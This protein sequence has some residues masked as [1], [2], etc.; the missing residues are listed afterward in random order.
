MC[1]A[2]GATSLGQGVPWSFRLAGNPLISGFHLSVSPL[3]SD[4]T[5]RE[6]PILL[7]GRMQR[8]TAQ[9]LGSL[10]TPG[11]RCGWPQHPGHQA[12]VAQP[13][14]SGGMYSCSHGRQQQQDSGQVQPA[15]GLL[16]L[17]EQQ[18]CGGP[19]GAISFHQG[20]G[21]MLGGLPE[22]WGLPQQE[23]HAGRTCPG[24][25]SRA[26]GASQPLPTPSVMCSAWTSFLE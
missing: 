3:E 16:V 25:W 7:C 23:D 19:A 10:S 26:A 4:T 9:G 5:R 15:L 11:G 17:G 2:T 24:T 13:R 6:E 21:P 22:G 12:A 1:V 18:V 8:G 14:G 20:P